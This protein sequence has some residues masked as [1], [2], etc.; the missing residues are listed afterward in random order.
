[1]SLGKKKKR[2]NSGD[3]SDTISWPSTRKNQSNN[4]ER[5]RTEEDPSLTVPAVNSGSVLTNWLKDSTLK[6]VFGSEKRRS[7]ELQELDASVASLNRLRDDPN[8][9]TQYLDR[10]AAAY[11]VIDRIEP[12]RRRREGTRE[13]ETAVSSLHKAAIEEITTLTDI[14]IRKDREANDRAQIMKDLPPLEDEQLSKSYVHGTDAIADI[15]L[16]GAVRGGTAATKVTGG[17][18][19]LR[20]QSQELHFFAS[21]TDESGRTIRDGQGYSKAKQNADSKFGGGGSKLN[22]DKWLPSWRHAGRP[23]V[24]FLEFGQEIGTKDG[25]IKSG[26]NDIKIIT[27]PLTQGVSFSTIPLQE[28][29]PKAIRMI[30]ED[31]VVRMLAFLAENSTD[32][33]KPKLPP[34]I[35]VLQQSTWKGASNRDEFTKFANKG[36]DFHNLATGKVGYRTY[37]TQQVLSILGLS[38]KIEIYA[39]PQQRTGAVEQGIDSRNSG[40]E[41]ATQPNDGVEVRRDLEFVADHTE[42]VNALINRLAESSHNQTSNHENVTAFKNYLMADP[43]VDPIDALV[44]ATLYPSL[45]NSVRG[46]LR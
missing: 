42:R 24:G 19:G 16:D 27:P 20:E 41:G 10:I 37:D 43:N 45:I 5:L 34:L 46:N 30:N 31:D 2:R 33:S 36:G 22:Q 14:L 13:R 15:L 39:F 29:G 11:E 38:D 4:S 40:V 1:M 23:I 26:E 18:D 7:K 44:A 25:T 6:N 32:S 8:K 35:R 28:M 21:E 17:T 9:N 3:N 12:W